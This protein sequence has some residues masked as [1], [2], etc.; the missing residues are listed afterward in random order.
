MQSV[1]KKNRPNE[2]LVSDMSPENRSHWMSDRRT[3]HIGRGVIS[4]L[5]VSSVANVMNFV[6][7][8]F[9]TTNVKIRDTPSSF[10]AGE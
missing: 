2:F 10:V 5:E 6:T 9:A 4:P 1:L 7:M 8:N 3:L